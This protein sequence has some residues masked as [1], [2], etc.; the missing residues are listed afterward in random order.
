MAEDDEADLRTGL[1]GLSGLLMSHQPLTETL[2]RVAEFAVQAVPAAEGA[3]VTLLEGERPAAVV[4]SAPFV[5]QIDDIQYRLG[6]GPCI[7]AV[8]QRCPQVSGSLGG[9]CRWPRFGPRVGRMGVHSALSLPLLL[10]DRVV[11]AMNIYAHAHEAFGPTA[12]RVGGLFAA[13]ATV[14]VFNAQV[15]AQSQQLAA[16]LSE[17]MTNR[18]TIDQAIGIVMSRTGVTAD[19]ALARLKTISQRQGA[20]LAQVARSMLDEAVRRARS[21]R[22]EPGDPG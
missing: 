17:A 15:L 2:I 10:P 18:A 20:K 4:A 22:E 12:V 16:Q 3:G 11:G 21:R 9:D 8:E 6:E 5:R 7:S 14:S 19:E 13:P 1:N